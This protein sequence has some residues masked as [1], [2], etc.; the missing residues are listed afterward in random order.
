MRLIVPVATTLLLLVGPAIAAEPTLERG[1][2][3]FQP[4][5]DESLVAE[6]F[7]LPAHTFDYQLRPMDV[8]TEQFQI[9]ELTFPSPVQTP[10][11]KNNTVYCE[12]YRPKHDVTGENKK[13][14]AVIVLH[15]LGGDF[16]LARMFCNALAQK[17]VA[18]LF[19]KMPYYG[20]RR[21]PA[22]SRR[23]VSPDPKETV[24]GLTQAVL[25]IRRAAAWLGSREEID[26]KRL[27]IFG[28]SLG[29][30]TGALAATAESRLSNVCLLLAGGDLGK[31]AWDSPELAIIRKRWLSGGG[32][33]EEF[34][35]ALREV[36][37]VR[38]AR[39]ISGRRILMMN[40]ANDEVI[41]KVCTESLWESFG[42]PPIHWFS[43][44]H[45]SCIWHL[46]EALSQVQTFFTATESAA[47]P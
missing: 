6:R 27:G 47:S 33:R 5:P 15:I 10:H 11:E 28:I 7:R 31:V 1:T 35:T 34:V 3:N 42:K 13:M 2:V 36:D 43:G 12:Y 16:P 18:A 46:P 20:P 26:A 24:E 4:A 32:T 25:D 41:P 37:P 21:D 23:M 40:A 9:L 39:S 38:Y 22:V 29:G 44:G 8:P 19:L 30:I 45:Y 17:G 14:P